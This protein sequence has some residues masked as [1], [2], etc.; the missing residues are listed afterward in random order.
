MEAAVSTEALSSAWQA[1]I[2][3]GPQ[4]PIDG[5]DEPERLDSINRLGE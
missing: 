2:T 5:E 3:N 1:W 4:G